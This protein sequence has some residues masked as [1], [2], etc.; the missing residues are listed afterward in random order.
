LPIIDEYKKV[1]IEGEKF[2]I[3][4]LTIIPFSLVHDVP[5][6][7]YLIKDKI[8]GYKIV[9][10]TDTGMIDNLS[11]KDVDCYVCESNCDE[12]NIDYEDAKSVRVY[13]THLSM[14]QTARFLYNNVN[15]NTKHCI[16]VH[17]SSKEEDY[18]KHQRHIESY[19][20]NE[21][22]NIIAIDQKLKEPLEIVL[23]EEIGGFDFD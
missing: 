1:V 7:G 12:D 13:E 15:H 22:L 16:L 3:K 10:I 17:I 11:F 4:D 18:L 14:Q 5:I 8:S 2:E 20:E 6:F 23:K 9:Y 19:L 21:K